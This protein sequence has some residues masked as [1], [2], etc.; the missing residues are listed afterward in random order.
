MGGAKALPQWW[1]RLTKGCCRE[2]G[3]LTPEENWAA[4]ARQ[5]KAFP[6]SA[7]PSF[8]EDKQ[9]VF[10]EELKVLGRIRASSQREE[11][12]RAQA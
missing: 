2:R 5:D 8:W 11:P 4:F 3:L 1:L 12:F 7:S 9:K 10:L 6:R